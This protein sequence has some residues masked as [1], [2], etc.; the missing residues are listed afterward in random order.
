MVLQTYYKEMPAVRAENLTKIYKLYDKPSDRLKELIFH[1]PFHRDFV[2]L[3]NVSFSLEKGKT[4]GIIG[5]NGAGKSTLLKILA[6]TLT[7]TRGNFEIKGIVSSLLELGSGFHPEFTGIENIL[8]YGSLLGI[9]HE[10]MKKKIDEI[11]EFSELGDF[12]N[13]PIKTYS[14]G[15][16]VRLAF[17]VATAVDPDILIIDEALSVGDQHFQKKCME[18]I[19]IFRKRG[20]TIVFCS[21]DMY[22][23]KTFCE[24]VMWLHHGREKML[25]ESAK[26]VKAYSGYEQEKSELF[27]K[28]NKLA[29]PVDSLNSSFLFIQDLT[30]HQEDKHGILIHFKVKSLEAL[31][32]HVGWAIVRKD[33]FQV[34]FMTT[35]ML[36]EEP[37]LFEG[38]RNI[39]IKIKDVNIVNGD[40]LM[41][42]GLFDKQA[43][44]P[45]AVDAIECTLNTDYE[46]LNSLCH[47]NSTFI[48]E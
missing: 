15:M 40:Y 1:K 33:G 20:K 5:D 32:G 42:V 25:D 34:S 19:E 39:T 35:K 9:D 13:Y 2:A 29:F 6:K 28:N 16:H 26:V 43:Y 14:S 7:Q 23:I 30:V 47:F 11:I 31:L 8:F 10:Y 18:R 48:I 27:R 17:S 36:N 4:L 41:Y 44:Q 3:D 12:I 38:I 45:I 37:T 22:Q 21:H 24:I 46:I